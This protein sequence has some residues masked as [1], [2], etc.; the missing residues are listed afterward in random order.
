MKTL[1][2]IIAGTTLAL[3]SLFGNI[4]AEAVAIPTGYIPSR[5]DINGKDF[6]LSEYDFSG[7]GR[8]GSRWVTAIDEYWGIGAKH[9][10]A[11]GTVTFNSGEQTTI[12]SKVT[13]PLLDNQDL[14]L[15]KFSTPLQ[16]TT[17]YDLIQFPVTLSGMPLL[18]GFHEFYYAGF[19]PS[20]KRTSVVLAKNLYP[21]YEGGSSF[22][23]PLVF[24]YQHTTTNLDFGYGVNGDSG[25][26][27]FLP[28]DTQ[29]YLA[30]VH[31]G[32]VSDGGMI[33]LGEEIERLTGLENKSWLYQDA[34][35]RYDKPIDKP[36]VPEPSTLLIGLLGLS[37][38]GLYREK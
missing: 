25:A 31:W 19:S 33:W 15:Y 12:E 8:A 38:I 21:N 22:A 5:H 3:S 9:H 6:H 30:G 10:Q 23:S 18:N 34:L 35:T 29:L 28:I 13:S 1:N 26:P 14:I 11:T 36:I 24:D 32:S 27:T 20:G 4:D 2:K 17:T 7:F 37:V 16:N